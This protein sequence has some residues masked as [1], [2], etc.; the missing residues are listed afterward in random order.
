M[1]N[2]LNM[3][4]VW[5]VFS[6]LQVSAAQAD[7]TAQASQNNVTT[8]IINGVAHSKTALEKIESEMV[9]MP[10]RNYEI[11]KYEIT[12]EIWLEVIGGE[13]WQQARGISSPSQF[14]EC[15][16]DCPVEN[17]SW[18]DT[19]QFINMLNYKTGRQYRLP[20]EIEWEYACD[21][22][23][24]DDYCGGNNIDALAWYEKN[25]KGQ[26]HPVG[27]KQANGYGLY[28]MS[29]NVEEW[30]G[31]GCYTHF[32]TEEEGCS[33]RTLRGG[34]WLSPKEMVKSASRNYSGSAFKYPQF[35]LRLARTIP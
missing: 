26:T 25:S 6:G 29:G 33:F 5:T 20:T 15:G 24:H 27:E 4:L 30:I 11:G 18:D 32:E 31:G 12:Q 9:V 23:S 34:S 8:Q 14:S 19:E 28:D 21:G 16:R 17:I 35:G 13:L 3:L 1:L 7:S 22:G 2:R 10:G